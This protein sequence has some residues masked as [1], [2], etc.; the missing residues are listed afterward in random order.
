M[1][2]NFSDENNSALDP[3]KNSAHFI[4]A[5]QDPNDSQ[6]TIYDH[7]TPTNPTSPHCQLGTS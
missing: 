6:P 1:L 2:G 7:E 3:S 4:A 5:Q